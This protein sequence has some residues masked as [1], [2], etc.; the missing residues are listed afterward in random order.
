MNYHSITYPDV[1][2]GLGCRVTLWLSGCPHHCPGCH[3]KQ[4]WDINSGKPFSEEAKKQLF[5][6][7]SL[8]YIQGITFSGGEPLFVH[9]IPKLAKLIEEIKIRFPNKDIWLYTGYTLQEI[10]D[11]M[12]DFEIDIYIKLIF[13]YTDYVVE[14]RYVEALRNTSLAFRGS[15]NQH[16]YKVINECCDFKYEEYQG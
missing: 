13:T 9:N 8:P 12:Y 1:N 5:D 11:M 15:S 16:I 14:G 7:L 6:I 10:K 4:T 2:N 3:N